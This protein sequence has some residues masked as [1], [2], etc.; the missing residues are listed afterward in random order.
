MRCLLASILL[1]QGLVLTVVADEPGVIAL[2]NQREGSTDWQL[3]NIQIEVGTH[4]SRAI[5]GYCSQLSYHTG[6]ELTVFVSTAQAATYRLDIYRMGYYGGRGA[7]KVLSIDQLTGSPQPEPIKGERDLLACNWSPAFRMPIP[8]TW[9]S[10]VYLG[11][12][13]LSDNGPESY[14]VFVVRDSRQADLVV[15]VSDFTWQA[16]NRWPRWN[17]LYDFGGSKWETKRS[18]L[19]GMDRPYARYYNGLPMTEAN[20]TKVV[21]SGEF[22]MW[23]F[24]LVYFLE[25]EGYDVTYLSNLDTHLRPHLLTRTKAFL[26]V[27]HDEYWTRQMHANVTMARDTGVSLLF[28]SGNSVFGELSLSDAPDGRAHRVM[29]RNRWFPDEQQLMGATSYGVGLTDWTV[30]DDSHWLFEGTG[31]TNGDAIPSLVGWEYHGPPLRQ[32]DSLTIV[33]RGKVNDAA[34][35]QLDKEYTALF[36]DGPLGNFVFNA[37]TCWWSLPLSTPPGTVPAARGDFSQ[38]DPRLQQMTRNLL[39][40]AIAEH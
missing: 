16:Y 15:Q 6:E 10:G 40:R 31:M 8:T 35:N 21:G 23:E 36:Y 13:S 28:L 29:S 7:R 39:R 22:L 17:S 26:S 19:I 18:N 4:R 5:E 24:P 1:I 11:K 2:E 38:E 20:A 33:A 27:G 9:V 32:D 12:L 37:A 3:S 30:V 14:I 34:G 25:R